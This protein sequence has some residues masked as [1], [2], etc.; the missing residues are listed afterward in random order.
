MIADLL[1][2]SFNNMKA[3]LHSSQKKIDH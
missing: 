1:Q 2:P 3:S